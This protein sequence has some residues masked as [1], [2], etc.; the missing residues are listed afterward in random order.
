MNLA[1][2]MGA[3]AIIMTMTASAILLA[4]AVLAA[5]KDTPSQPASRPPAP[6]ADT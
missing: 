5:L 2:I 1:S 3:F 6:T 4:S